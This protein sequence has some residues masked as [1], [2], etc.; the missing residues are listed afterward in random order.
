MRS[1]DQ[2]VVSYSAAT[3]PLSVL[4]RLQKE[5]ADTLDAGEIED[6]DAFT[7]A[8]LLLTIAIMKLEALSLEC[9]R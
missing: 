6:R 1:A 7:V 9:H 4:V 2:M 3:M 8:N 5:N